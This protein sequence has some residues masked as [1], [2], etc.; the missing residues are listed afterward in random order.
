MS[1]ASA[2]Y[3]NLRHPNKN[4]R[5]DAAMA[6]GTAADAESVQALTMHL[7]D[8]TD[9]FV[10]ETIVWALVRI[11]PPAVDPTI[12]LLA[13]A[14]AATRTQAAHAL[15]KLDDGRAVPAL[16]EAL[17]D[18]DESVVQKSVY[19][20]GVLGDISALPALLKLLDRETTTL[21][22]ATHDALVAFGA[23]AQPALTARLAEMSCS[24][25]AR[26]AIVEIVAAIG[27]ESA[28]SS[29]STALR[30]ADWQVRFAAVNAL[31]SAR[32]PDLASWLTPL[33]GDEHAHVRALATRVLARR[34]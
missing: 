6:L 9:F 1:D 26:V 24:T 20:L 19:A 16:L 2:H 29:L 11:G 33:A 3:S 31:S 4:V 5:L 23:A 10:R 12:G 32:I 18:A 13:H 34:R 30:D 25:N 17:G 21:R 14:D 8:E 22:N 15:S 7:A 28:I 27:G